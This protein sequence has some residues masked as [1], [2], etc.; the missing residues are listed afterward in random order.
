MD[1]PS[2]ELPRRC[3]R[4][5]IAD[6]DS[7]AG[8]HA[9]PIAGEAEAEDGVVVLGSADAVRRAWIIEICG[10]ASIRTDD[11]PVGMMYHHVANDA[12]WLETVPRTTPKLADLG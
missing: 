4:S 8:D 1:G 5:E 6:R 10:R 11:Q 9:G 2:D 12:A 3:A 7:D